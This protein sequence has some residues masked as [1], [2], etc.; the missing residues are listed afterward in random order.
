[1]SLRAVFLAKQSPVYKASFDRLV[2]ASS[3][4][5]APRNDKHNSFDARLNSYEKRTPS[6]TEGVLSWVEAML[7]PE[8]DDG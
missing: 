8:V 1:M 4:K 5:N 7:R 3:Q 2:I 6:E